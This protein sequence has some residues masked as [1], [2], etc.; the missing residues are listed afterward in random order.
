MI[1]HSSLGVVVTAKAVIGSN[2]TF[3]GGNCIGTKGRALAHGDVTIGNGVIFG[4]NAV[5][6]GPIRI[7]NR[8][9]IS[10]GSVAMRDVGDNEVVG[11]V[12]ARLLSVR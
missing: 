7:G 4:A 5:A 1:L 6:L 9:V 10:A 2:V 12:P 8:A 3:T 11:G